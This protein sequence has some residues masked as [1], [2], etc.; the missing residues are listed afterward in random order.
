MQ[1]W[2]ACTKMYLEICIITEPLK[3]PNAPEMSANR[4]SICTETE[5]IA[6]GHVAQGLDNEISFKESLR[7]WER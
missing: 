3:N 6:L 1:T 2:S 5:K 4:K 7:G